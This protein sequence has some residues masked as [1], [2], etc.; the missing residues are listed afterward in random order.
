[1]AFSREDLEKYEKQP[2]KQVDDKVNPFRGATPA[3]AADPAAIAA[4][5]AGQSVDA[6]Q[7]DTAQGATSVDD[8]TPIVDEDGTLGDPTDSGEGTSD[9]RRGTR[10]PHPPI[11]AAN[12]N[13]TR[14]WLA[15]KRKRNLALGRRP[16]RGL[17]RNA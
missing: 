1:M 13:P 15:S 3:R 16:R 14:T 2:Q 9:D 4:V 10:P 7:G 12:R 11:S 17:L 5:A 6:T 8:D